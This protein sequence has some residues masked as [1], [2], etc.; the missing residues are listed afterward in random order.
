[1][2]TTTLSTLHK[3]ESDSSGWHVV[4]EDRHQVDTR[5]SMNFTQA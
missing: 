3:C 2:L 1:M 4:A 5:S